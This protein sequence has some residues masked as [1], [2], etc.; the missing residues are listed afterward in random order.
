MKKLVCILN[1]AAQS[2][3]WPLKVF[4]HVI[5]RPVIR[6]SGAIR[7]HRCIFYDKTFRILY[8]G[9]VTFF[10]MLLL[11]GTNQ[12]I[13][14]GYLEQIPLLSDHSQYLWAVNY[15]VIFL[16]AVVGLIRMPPGNRFI[17]AEGLG[18]THRWHMLRTTGSMPRIPC[19][20]VHS[21]ID[22][23]ASD[24]REIHL[25]SRLLIPPLTTPA[26]VQKVTY[27]DKQERRYN[28][29]IKKANLADKWEAKYKGVTDAPWWS[30]H[31]L[32]PGLLYG[33]VVPRGHQV[34]TVV[35]SRK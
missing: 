20:M 32:L 17:F 5:F 14:S 6:M 21:L 7:W 1:F 33:D 27:A 2:L 22:V 4:S 16:V 15:V 31:V 35:L 23:D 29:Y 3:R 13:K 30:R 25:I 26:I 9:A 18:H 28:G 11:Y 34:G 12:A 10:S 19:E 8:L 24:V